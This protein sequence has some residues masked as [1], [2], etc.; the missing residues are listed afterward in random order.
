VLESDA[1]AEGETAPW[2][3]VCE[4]P[5]T[6]TLPIDGSYRV[7]GSG[8]HSSRPFRLPDD[9]SAVAVSAEMQDSSVAA[10]MALTIVGGVIASVGLLMIAGGAAREVDNRN[11]ETLIISGAAV[12][13]GGAIIGTIGVV[14]LLVKSQNTESKAHVAF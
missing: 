2:Y 4:A 5:C 10:P 1:T 11:G 14:M 13:G 8:Y 12:G 3:V 9:R 6:R 7:A